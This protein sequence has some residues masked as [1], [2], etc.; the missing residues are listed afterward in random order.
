MSLQAALRKAMEVSLPCRCEAQMWQH[1]A[2]P[3]PARSGRLG[4]WVVSLRG[5][6]AYIR[7][8]MIFCRLTNRPDAANQW[9]HY[10]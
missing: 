8:G 5:F 4:T 1:L 7:S 6:T 10:R 9:A 2:W 3:G